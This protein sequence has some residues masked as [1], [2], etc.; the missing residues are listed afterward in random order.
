MCGIVGYLGSR[1]AL[2]ILMDGLKRLEYRGYDSAGIATTCEGS[3]L[4]R[5]AVGK[6]QNLEELLQESP[7]PGTTGIGHTRWATHGPVTVANAHPQIT[8]GVAVVHNGI[9]E[10]ARH[11][12]SLLRDQGYQVKSDTDT[13]AISLMCQSFLDRAMSPS[14]A[15]RRTVAMLRG[16]FAVCLIFAGQE[17]LVF[18]ARRGSPLVIGHGQGEMFV[19]SDP[20]ALAGYTNRIT[21][22]ED[23]DCTIVSRT[24]LSVCDTDELPIVRTAQDV[25]IDAAM[26]G[27]DG[28]D[29]HMAKEIFEQPRVLRNAIDAI[30]PPDRKMPAV[31][32]D[33]NFRNIDRITLVGCGTAY[34]AA[35]IA[36][37]WLEYLARIPTETE[38]ASE[39]RYRSPI[40]GKRD[41]SIFISQSGETA[42]TLAALRF[43]A[44]QRRSNLS[45]LNSVNSSMA[46]ES[47]MVLPIH[48][49]WESAVASTKAFTC[50]LATL[51]GLT[52]LA[53]RQRSHLN[54]ASESEMKRSL[55]RVPEL[56]EASLD[57]DEEIQEVAAE[58][59]GSTSAIFLGRG[60]MYPLALEGALKL[61]EVTYIHAEGFPSGELKH[62]PI[63]LVEDGIPVVVLA[64][65]GALFEKTLSNL[66]EV[67][68][69]GG[70]IIMITDA[71]GAET[72][73]TWRTL[74]LPETCLFSAPIVF[75]IPLQLLAYHTGVARGVDIDKPQNLAKSVTVE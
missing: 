60:T 65:S 43:V 69:R 21:Y 30:A 38:I 71:M 46:R 2:P 67:K 6:I 72:T 11:L 1:D 7:I 73:D 64:P 37:Y 19:A 52:V 45:V 24:G 63:S 12:K 34:L 23:G 53:A 58:I 36:S 17:G 55:R 20:I 35:K 15:A 42:D 68:A 74:V 27:K 25:K 13:E 5:R 39:Y 33:L 50:Q 41:L 18:A 22:L 28:F 4:N 49:G 29:F 26:S 75:T 47:D 32:S 66:E 3:L 59:A 57:L 44:E 16:S 10:N 40:L 48:A 56:V 54:E 14:E 51:A 9:V 70:R 8:A 31:V 61:K 62:G